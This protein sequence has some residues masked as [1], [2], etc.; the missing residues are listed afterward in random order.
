LTLLDHPRDRCEIH[1]AQIATEP[2]RRAALTRPSRE[3]RG[4]DHDWRKQASALK[5]AQPY[6]GVCGHGP[7]TYMRDGVEHVDDLT[8]DHIVALAYGGTD[9]PSNLRV[10]HRSFNSSK[11]SRSAGICRIVRDRHNEARQ[12]RRAHG[13]FG[14]PER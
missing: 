2:E 8:V 7:Y 14:T 3:S 10:C 11:G 9:D 5:E 6:C 4:Y 1:Q 13:E 12:R